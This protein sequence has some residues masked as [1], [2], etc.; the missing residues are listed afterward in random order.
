MRI[1]GKLNIEFTHEWYNSY[2]KLLY[3]CLHTYASSRKPSQT[4]VAVA[5]WFGFFV[6]VQFVKSA[7]KKT[8]TLC[9][10]RIEKLPEKW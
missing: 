2:A 10:L 5:V 8:E 1:Y 4:V 7:R 3:M 9:I 6:V